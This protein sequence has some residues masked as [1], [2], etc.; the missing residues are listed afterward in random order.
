MGDPPCGTVY[1]VKRAEG[2]LFFVG[3]PA[4]TCGSYILVL[5]MEV[6]LKKKNHV[7]PRQMWRMRGPQSLNLLSLHN[8][9]MPEN[10]FKRLFRKTFGHRVC[11]MG[12]G[13]LS[14]NILQPKRKM[15]SPQHAFFHEFPPPPEEVT[16]S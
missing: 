5:R 11:F 15:A 16:F 7:F 2:M 8:S 4:C 14:C 12:I 6:T 13:Q 1:D 9:V 3:S 10:M